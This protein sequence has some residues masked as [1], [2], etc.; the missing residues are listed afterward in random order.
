[1]VRSIEQANPYDE[2][3]SRQRRFTAKISVIEVP[4]ANPAA[5]SVIAE[6][7]ISYPGDPDNQRLV[8]RSVTGPIP[9]LPARE[10]AAAAVPRHR[11]PRRG[12]IAG[13]ACAEQGQVW[14][15]DENG[16]PDTANPVAIIDD[17]FS[18]GGTGNIPGAVDF[19]HS[20]MFNND[21]TVLNTVDESFGSRLPDDDQWSPDPG[22][23]H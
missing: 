7:P 21:G 2:D 14:E 8:E 16:I 1:M 17:E 20:V 13:A 3:R 10:P 18:S 23:P 5:S 4:L 6:P 12:R 22:I 15:I 9:L 19:F 11:G